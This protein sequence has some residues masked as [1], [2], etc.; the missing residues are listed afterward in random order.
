M[1]SAINHKKRSHRSEAAHYQAARQMKGSAPRRL[2]LY[3]G[4]HGLG[5]M[6]ALHRM[7]LAHRAPRRREQKDKTEN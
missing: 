1:S 6:A 7:G 4:C 3:T 2:G 5:I